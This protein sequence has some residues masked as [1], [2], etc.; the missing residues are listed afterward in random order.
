MGITIRKLNVGVAV[1]AASLAPLSSVAFADGEKMSFSVEGGV[2]SSEFTRDKLGA[3]SDEVDS[4]IGLYGSVGVVRD[5]QPGWDWSASASSLN[6]APNTETETEDGG[7]GFASYTNE[8]DARFVNFDIGRNFDAAGAQLRIGLGIEALSTTQ[9]KG[10]SLSNN[11]DSYFDSDFS[12]SFVGL[13]PQVSA[14]GSMALQQGSPLSVYGGASAALTRGVLTYD[15]GLTGQNP[16]PVGGSVT[17]DEMANV[18][19]GVLDAGIE[20]KITDST[21]FRAGIR[22]DIF[23][24]DS[25]LAADAPDELF[26]DEVTSDTAYVGVS[27]S[28]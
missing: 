7:P 5:I 27:V 21:A 14:Q 20:Y 1:G 2:A 16:D 17:E 11:P 3:P 13:G 9:D 10:L 24:F 8:F 12:T 23:R 6:F 4:D 15:K 18:F 28:F 19:H 25:E 22:R 26:L